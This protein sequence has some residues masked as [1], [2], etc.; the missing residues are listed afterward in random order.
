M[1]QWDTVCPTWDTVCPAGDEGCDMSQWIRFD[2]GMKKPLAVPAAF[3]W[4]RG[5]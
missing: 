4:A 1:S 2:G 3:L 5:I